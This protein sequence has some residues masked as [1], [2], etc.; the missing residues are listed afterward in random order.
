MYYWIILVMVA[1]P[2]NRS[3]ASGA[4]MPRQA[5]FRVISNVQSRFSFSFVIAIL[6]LG[7]VLIAVP[8][9]PHEL[10]TVC[11]KYN[12]VKSCQVW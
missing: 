1:T 3:I 11:A 9:K 12:S 2:L 5:M 8:E 6:S 10:A 4:I 7:F